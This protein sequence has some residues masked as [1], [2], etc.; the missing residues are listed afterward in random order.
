MIYGMIY[1]TYNEYHITIYTVGCVA[2]S[3]SN[4][5]SAT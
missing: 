4:S 1:D 5:N 3:T 2:D